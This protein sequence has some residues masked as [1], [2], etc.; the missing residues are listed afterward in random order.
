T[1]HGLIKHYKVSQGH[2]TLKRSVCKKA[3][4]RKAGNECAY[5]G[6]QVSNRPLLEQIESLF[7]YLLAKASKTIHKHMGQIKY[8][9]FL[10]VRVYSEEPV[11]VQSLPLC[12]GLLSIPEVKLSCKTEANKQIRNCCKNK[13]GRHTPMEC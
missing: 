1:L 9:D 10:C 11:K 3:V 8:T 7:T 2:L 13:D 4:Q 6:Q 5:L 12:W